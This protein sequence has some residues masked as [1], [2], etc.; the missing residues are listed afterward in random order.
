MS[1]R[2]IRAAVAGSS[3]LRDQLPCQDACLAEVHTV[4][5][6]E[7]LL[8][9]VADGAGSALRGGSGARLAC[10]TARECIIGWLAA[11]PSHLPTE[12]LVAEWF[13]SV[14]AALEA[15][16][17]SAGLAVREFATT[18]LLALIVPRTAAYGH[19]G[20]GGIVVDNGAGLELVFWPEAGEYANMTR[21]ITDADALEHVRVAVSDSAP[22]EVAV[23]TD[24]IQRLALDF[25]A[26]SVHTPFF[27]PMLAVLRQQ[28]HDVCRALEGQLL[29]F[30][31]SPKVNSR[32][33]DDKTLVLASLRGS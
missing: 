9:L 28:S 27:A 10:E 25:K 16:A 17:G 13:A 3:H 15:A 5:Q 7:A 1:W 24:G 26:G 23:F 29:A 8:I 11:H 14:R 19:I 18:L 30:L 2:L 12:R 31:D 33:D 22:D 20:D 4:P 21:F 6:G 32:T